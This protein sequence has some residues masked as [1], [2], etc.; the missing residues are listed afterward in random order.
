MTVSPIEISPQFGFSSFVINL[1]KV[2]FPAPLA[3]ITPTIPPGG[4]L[5]LK[6]SIN[7]LSSKDL[8]TFSKFITSLPSLGAGGITRLLELI[9]FCCSFAT[10]S[11]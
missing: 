6:L 9:S 11:S 2:V 4:N 8:D 3:P 5:K 10:N 1:N 7:N